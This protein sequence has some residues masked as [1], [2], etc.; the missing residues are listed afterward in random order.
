MQG[1]LSLSFIRQ[2]AIAP[3]AQPEKSRIISLVK[4]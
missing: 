1:K 3:Y 4:Y 2:P